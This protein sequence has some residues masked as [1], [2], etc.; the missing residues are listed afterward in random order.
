RRLLHARDK[1]HWDPRPAVLW[2]ADGKTRAEV[3]DL[4]GRSVR[5]LAEWLRRFRNR[6]LDALCTLHHRGDPGNLS[7]GQVERLKQEIGTGRFHNSAQVRLLVEE[8]SRPGPR[9][10]TTWC[11][12]G[13]HSSEI[14]ARRTTPPFGRSGPGGRRRGFSENVGNLQGKR[15][16]SARD[17]ALRSSIFWCL[18]GSLTTESWSSV[19]RA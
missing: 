10:S 11:S 6:G 15:T 16:A 3:A 1:R 12:T 14:W 18:S 19:D 17:H 8:T 7:A 13:P 4:L 2:V 9:V 5:Q